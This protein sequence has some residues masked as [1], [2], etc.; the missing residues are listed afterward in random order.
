MTMIKGSKLENKFEYGDKVL[1][2]PEGK[3]YDFGYISK[4]GQAVIYNEGE[5][6]MEDSYAV[7]LNQLTKIKK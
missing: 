5:R 4:T 3:I 6:N 7:E 2:N 1:F